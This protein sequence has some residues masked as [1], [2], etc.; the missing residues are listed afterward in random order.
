MVS[1][2]MQLIATLTKLF[3]LDSDKIYSS[4]EQRER[5]DKAL[6]LNSGTDFGPCLLGASPKKP[7]IRIKRLCFTGQGE[8]FVDGS[9]AQ[10]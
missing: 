10:I 9:A 1:I 4:E 2:Q 5:V 8:L 6:K 7:T 3:Q